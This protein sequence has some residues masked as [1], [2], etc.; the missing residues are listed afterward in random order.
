MCQLETYATKKLAYDAQPQ[1]RL[2]KIKCISK[3]HI[4]C[5]NK[6]KDEFDYEIN[7]KTFSESDRISSLISIIIS[8]NDINFLRY[9]NTLYPL[10]EYI[11]ISDAVLSSLQIVRYL[12]EEIKLE[13]N[14]NFTKEG[15]IESEID[16]L[17][18]ALKNGCP[19][20]S[21]HLKMYLS[22]RE[23]DIKN[24]EWFNDFYNKL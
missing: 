12:R 9:I 23:D 24:D 8:S 15:V 1:E 2:N 16:V 18:Y 4:D 14:I 7:P 13:W 22:N 17:K 19:Y 20:V 5:F 11:D 3:D 21:W 6:Y 10:E